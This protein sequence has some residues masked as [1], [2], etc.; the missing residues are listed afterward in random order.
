MLGV[1]Q[2]VSGMTILTQKSGCADENA[3]S[4]GAKHS[5]GGPRQRRNWF[6]E[7][8]SRRRDYNGVGPHTS[9]CNVTP[10][11]FTGGCAAVAPSGS[12]SLV[13]RRCLF[14]REVCKTFAGIMGPMFS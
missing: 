5:K 11:E 4:S 2:K 3:G 1:A 14:S 9:L 6:T 13:I 8:Q 12:S 10:E 7:E